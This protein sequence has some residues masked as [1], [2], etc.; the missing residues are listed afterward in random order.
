MPEGRLELKNF[1]GVESNSAVR[2]FVVAIVGFDS[3]LFRFSS[4]VRCSSKKRGPDRSALT[5]HHDEMLDVLIGFKP[6]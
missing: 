5:G 2:W 6:S 4:W 1:F 3:I